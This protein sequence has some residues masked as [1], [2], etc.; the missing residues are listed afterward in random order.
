M[1]P[2]CLPFY[3]NTMLGSDGLELVVR[4][5]AVIS[6]FIVPV[7]QVYSRRLFNLLFR[8]LRWFA[9]DGLSVWCCLFVIE[10]IMA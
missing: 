8:V 9:I 4:R 2:C 7:V 6:L 1:F 3:G 10:R 5:V